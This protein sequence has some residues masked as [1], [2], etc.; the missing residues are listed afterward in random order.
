MSADNQSNNSAQKI[1]LID[2]VCNLCVS[3]VHFIL[4]HEKNQDIKFA[5][6]QDSIGADL[7]QQ[8]GL[9]RNDLSS[10][11]LIKN[12]QAYQYSDAA[13][14]ISRDLKLPWSLL[15][16]FKFLPKF[17]RD[18]CYRLV[19]KNRYKIFGKKESCF[20]PTPELKGRFL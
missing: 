12:N 1:V 13:L 2:G 14:E 15:T 5:S 16:Y 7:M 18:F 19:A 3:V 9:A 8:Y 10:V 11:V 6:I 4:K 17:I 20:I